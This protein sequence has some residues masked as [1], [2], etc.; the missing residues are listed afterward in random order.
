VSH[1]GP[2][3]VSLLS[4]HDHHDL[5][6]EEEFRLRSDPRSEVA[7]HVPPVDQ[8]Y[9]RLQVMAE[10]RMTIRLDRSP[11]WI[12]AV[13]D[14]DQS[15]APPTAGSRSGVS[16]GQ[17]APSLISFS[18]LLKRPDRPGRAIRQLRGVVPVTVLARRPS[19]LIVPLRGPAGQKAE[20]QG[21]SLEVREIRAEPGRPW[22][23]KLFLRTE[24]PREETGI[25]STWPQ[26]GQFE[27]VDEGGQPLQVLFSAAYVDKDLTSVTLRLV[28]GKGARIPAELR[29]HSLTRSTA[30]VPF[31]FSDIRIP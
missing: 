6:L 3:R 28:D 12:E 27:L 16:F 10:P 21:F 22:A 26:Q 5:I 19:P 24:D 25:P 17:L 8:F 11:R 23:A 30:E 1:S 31:E 15:L 7:P 18:A 4:V 9:V 2:F 14:R 13:D 29:Y 20:G